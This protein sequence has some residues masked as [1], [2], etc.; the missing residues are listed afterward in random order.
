MSGPTDRVADGPPGLTTA[1]VPAYY[2]LGRTAGYRL[3]KWLAPL[4]CAPGRWR[5]AELQQLDSDRAAAALRVLLTGDTPEL[6][7]GAYVHRRAAA[8]SPSVPD[9]VVHDLHHR[10]R[11]QS[12]ANATPIAAP[13]ASPDYSTGTIVN[14]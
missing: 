2:R 4:Q 12:A 5:L 1:E 9:R 3:T 10:D 6:D 8:P 13:R 11:Q 7:A 14:E